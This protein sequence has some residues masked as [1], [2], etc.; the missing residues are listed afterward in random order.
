MI[1]KFFNHWISLTGVTSDTSIQ[2]DL[3]LKLWELLDA[4]EV[5]HWEG[6]YL[7][8]SAG[9]GHVESY[10]LSI[11]DA[12][13]GIRG[14]LSVRFFMK[15]ESLNASNLGRSSILWMRLDLWVSHHLS[16]DT[17]CLS[18]EGSRD[19][20]G[21]M[22]GHSYLPTFYFSRWHRLILVSVFELPSS[23]N[24]TGDS[25]PCLTLVTDDLTTNCFDEE[26]V[27]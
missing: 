1:L 16:I 19:T 17:S 10:L 26:G 3:R 6:I 24:D 2:V 7:S 11:G 12:N 5:L 15:P 27:W 14:S 4:A 22:A 8:S 21:F 13:N 20:W 18:S 9:L 25:L 23:M